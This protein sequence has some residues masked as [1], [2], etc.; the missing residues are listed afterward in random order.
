MSVVRLIHVRIKPEQVAEAE[1]VW[2]EECAPLMI[3]QQGCLSEKLL[4]CTDS[5]GEYISYAEWD[6]AQDIERYLAGADHREILRHTANL[7]SDKTV[8][9]LYELV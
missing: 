5:P 3:R 6:N 8:V 9:K 2:K 4:K 1:R 7:K